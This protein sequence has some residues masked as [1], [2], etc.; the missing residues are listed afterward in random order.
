[1]AWWS[2]LE[3]FIMYARWDYAETWP[4]DADF[5]ERIPGIFIDLEIAVF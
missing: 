3:I 2:N 1:M 4:G 5:Q